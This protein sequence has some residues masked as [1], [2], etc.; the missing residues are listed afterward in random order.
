M[1][2]AKSGPVYQLKISLAG[3]KPPVWRRVEVMDCTLSKLHE[4]IQI[5]MDWDG[6]HLWAFDIGGEQYGE[7]PSGEME[8][9]S[10]R[11]VKLGVTGRPLLGNP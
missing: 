10:A 7:D 4:I 9:T 2:K 8:M 6:Y 3:I 1:A 5:V 11:K